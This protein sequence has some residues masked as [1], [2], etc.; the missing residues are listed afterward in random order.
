M[1]G[2]KEE[3]GETGRGARERASQCVEDWSGEEG[4]PKLTIE[5]E[6]FRMFSIAQVVHN[7]IH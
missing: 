1:A 7:F 5:S 4:S 3:E 2:R 6:E